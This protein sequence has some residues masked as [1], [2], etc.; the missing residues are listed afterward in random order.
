MTETHDLSSRYMT[1]IQAVSAL[2][3]SIARMQKLINHYE[4]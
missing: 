3:R 2:F 1:I 4:K